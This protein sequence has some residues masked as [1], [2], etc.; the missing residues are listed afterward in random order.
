MGLLSRGGGP[1][2]SMC[3]K[4][5]TLPSTSAQPGTSKTV[6]DMWAGDGPLF[7]HVHEV[8]PENGHRQPGMAPYQPRVEVSF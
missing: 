1:A 4:A 5:S 8:P 3:S 2:V 7:G 6:L